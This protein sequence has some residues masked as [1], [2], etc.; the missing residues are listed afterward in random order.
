MKLG[1]LLLSFVALL[2]VTAT[3]NVASIVISKNPTSV[4]SVPVSDST[5]GNGFGIKLP[6][7]LTQR[8]ADLLSKAYRIAKE[9]GHKHPQILQ[10]I[11][12][13]ETQAGEYHRY[14]V[15]GQEFGLRTNERYYGVAQ[16]KLAAAK[17]VLAKWP[18]LRKDFGFHTVTDEEIIAKLIENDDFNLSVAS[19]Y[20]LILKSYGYNT[21]QQLALAYNQGPG[22]ARNHDENTHHY[23]NGV[24]KNLQKISFKN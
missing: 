3:F 12:L 11:I 13:Q 19:K 9:D 6:K 8:Q 24:M 21:I 17:D 2:A 16:I 7:N 10:G 20:L 1:N 18:D 15:A 22:G 23:S 5:V 4:I 14:K